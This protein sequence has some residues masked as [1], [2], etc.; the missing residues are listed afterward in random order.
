MPA[1]PRAGGGCPVCR[2]RLGV[3]PYR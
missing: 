1:L 3:E 2:N